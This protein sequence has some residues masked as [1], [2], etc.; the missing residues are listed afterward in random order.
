M[1][2]GH[3]TS[4]LTSLSKV[5]NPIAQTDSLSEATPYILVSASP[6]PSYRRDLEVSRDI[7]KNLNPPCPAFLRQ[8]MA[9]IYAVAK[10]CLISRN[11]LGL[12]EITFLAL[13]NRASMT[14]R[15]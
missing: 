15:R 8:A 9:R 11:T 1:L 7:L 6:M 3:K 10:I 12:H 2:H 14:R 5:A 4:L 13:S